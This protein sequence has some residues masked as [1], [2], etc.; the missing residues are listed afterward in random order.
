MTYFTEILST[1]KVKRQK[2]AISVMA[3][4]PKTAQ[5]TYLNKHLNSL[6]KV[7]SVRN[8]YQY[9]NGPHNSTWKL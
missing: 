4:A 8:I 9:Q 1:E 6:K 7:T 2:E 5:G 3:E